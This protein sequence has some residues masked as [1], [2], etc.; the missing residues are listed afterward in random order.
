[1]LTTRRCTSKGRPSQYS[2]VIPPLTQTQEAS[3]QRVG[4]KG[5]PQ[6][7]CPNHNT[8]AFQQNRKS[9]NIPPKGHTLTTI[10][11]KE[12]ETH[13]LYSTNYSSS[14]YSSNYSSNA[15]ARRNSPTCIVCTDRTVHSLLSCCN[16][17]A[18]YFQEQAQECIYS[19]CTNTS[20]ELSEK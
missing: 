6:V 12:R 1:M 10:D 7:H 19:P 11:W 16:Y 20:L 14:N 4:T 18:V 2:M 13:S 8:N 15:L 3:A 17:A 9:H 5:L